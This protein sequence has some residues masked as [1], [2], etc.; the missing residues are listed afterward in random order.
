MC[1][2]T[3]ESN[4]QVPKNRKKRHDHEA[5]RY[6]VQ[7]IKVTIMNVPYFYLYFS[8]GKSEDVV[9]EEENEGILNV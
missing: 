2:V 7:D 3:V 5:G 6:N 4:I 9:L 1:S 8:I